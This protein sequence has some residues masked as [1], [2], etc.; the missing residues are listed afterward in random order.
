MRSGGST[1]RRNK[2]AKRLVRLSSPRFAAFLLAHFLGA[3]NENEAQAPRW[4]LT[5]DR[6]RLDGDGFLTIARHLPV[7][8]VV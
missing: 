7:V 4:Y 1:S 6:A 8:P 5:G 2:F 3:A